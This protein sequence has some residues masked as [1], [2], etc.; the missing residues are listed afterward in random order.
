[1][2]LVVVGLSHHTSALELRERLHFPPESIPGALL[3]LSKRLDGGAAVILSTCNRVELYAH[4]P[5][6]R[7]D[8]GAVLRAF[9][10][11]H[12]GV[13]EAEFANA[14]YTY[15]G[16]EAAAH[17][18]RVA[19]SLDSLVVG[20]GQILGQVHDAYM[21]AHA[22]QTTDKV[23]SSL[24]QRAFAVAKD[25]RTRSGIGAGR[26]SVASVAVDL[27]VSIF[28]ELAGKTVMIIGSGEMGEATMRHLRERGAGEPL[29][30]NRTVEKA[31]EL[32]HRLGG[33]PIALDEL[34]A[35]L[36]RADI[37]ITSAAAD[38]AI[39]DSDRMERALKRRGNDP[40]FVIDIAVPR[41]VDPAVGALDN[42]Y[43]YD[44]DALREVADANLEARRA[45]IARCMELVDAGVERFD[46]WLHGLVA[47]PT[48]LSM[49]EELNAIRERELAKTLAALP[50]LDEKQR[51]E[52]AYLT[53]RIV[54][55][56]LQQPMT[57]LK[58]EVT[59]HDPGT[60]LHIVKRIFGLKETP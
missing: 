39:L 2:S 55:S 12:R 60:V 16:R 10:S 18:F 17:L 21:L 28:M 8:L 54:N 52:I 35:H 44:V 33:R 1:M 27:A 6:S 22:Q 14:L 7:H 32:A 38:E 57:Q 50:E 26:V 23:L 37:V 11:E 31:R 53:R 43:L 49:S 41:N 30:V 45:E 47:E 51:E 25:V 48:I 5:A 3:S 34:D 58:H 19:S 56:I 46:Q 9:L 24:F 40:V 20:E 36:H 15:A 4:T 42:V 29:L 59:H 13:P